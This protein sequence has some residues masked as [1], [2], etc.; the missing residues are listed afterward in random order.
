MLKEFLKFTKELSEVWKEF[1]QEEQRKLDLEASLQR[2]RVV[3]IETMVAIG[4]TTLE[5]YRELGIKES[6]FL[7][8]STKM[9]DSAIKEKRIRDHQ[10]EIQ[11]ADDAYWASE[12]SANDFDE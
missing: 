9:K 4:A 8:A 10:A 2:D 3:F 1:R 12:A 7:L 6:E 5:N 11:S